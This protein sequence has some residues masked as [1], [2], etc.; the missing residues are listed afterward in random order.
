MVGSPPHPSGPWR[1]GSGIARRPSVLLHLVE[2][3]DSGRKQGCRTRH[4]VKI[5]AG[6]PTENP[7]LAI[8]RKSQIAT[9]PVGGRIAAVAENPEVGRTRRRTQFT[10]QHPHRQTKRQLT[11]GIA[12]QPKGTHEMKKY[13]LNAS[14]A[15]NEDLRRFRQRTALQLHP[16]PLRPPAE[17]DRYTWEPSLR[18]AENQK[19]EAQIQRRHVPHRPPLRGSGCIWPRR[20]SQFLPNEYEIWAQ[21]HST[22]EDFMHESFRTW[23]WAT[24]C[25]GLRVRNVSATAAGKTSRI[26]LMFAKIGTPPR[27]QTWL[28]QRQ[29]SI[30]KLDPAKTTT[31]RQ[32]TSK[33]LAAVA[34]GEV[35][36]LL[37]RQRSACKRKPEARQSL[38]FSCTPAAR[39]SPQAGTLR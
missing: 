21:L 31:Y 39:F 30:A 12:A 13:N 4:V 2:P 36:L 38:I 19:R 16:S 14:P 23:T 3:M 27:R 8:A 32:V 10:V 17:T 28:A 18:D 9:P 5:A 29:I 1:A 15:E 24:A 37:R 34:A 22:P 6:F 26:Y 20:W 7:F 25:G 11:R 35:G 33:A